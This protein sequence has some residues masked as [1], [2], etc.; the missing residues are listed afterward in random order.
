[1]LSFL[2][3]HPPGEIIGYLLCS[4]LSWSLVLQVGKHQR[5]DYLR[6]ML[7]LLEKTEGLVNVHLLSSEP[8]QCLNADCRRPI[9]SCD[10]VTI[11]C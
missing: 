1:M 7:S 4:R 8:A 11:R 5:F 9:S 3:D 10:I 2:G 6:S